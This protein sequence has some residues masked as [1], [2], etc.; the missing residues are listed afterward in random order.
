LFFSFYLRVSSKA[1]KH[2]LE[3][4]KDKP[5]K[6]RFVPVFRLLKQLINCFC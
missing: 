2:L 5:P 4:K 6:W 1:D 3:R